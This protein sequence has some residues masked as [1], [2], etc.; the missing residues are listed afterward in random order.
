MAPANW[1][2]IAVTIHQLHCIIHAACRTHAQMFEEKH[3]TDAEIVRTTN[4]S[5]PKLGSL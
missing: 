5:S 1:F 3:V 4:N 2:T